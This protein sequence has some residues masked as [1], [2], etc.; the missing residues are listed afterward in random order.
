M[1]VV[2]RHVV[3]W[4]M[5][6]GAEARLAPLMESLRGLP[7]EIPQIHELTCGPAQNTNG[8]D[9]ALVVDFADTAALAAYREHPAHAPILTD[10]RELAQTIAVVDYEVPTTTG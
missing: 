2:T 5:K 4:T 9:A 10:L 1:H 8:F 6:A 7:R 3:V